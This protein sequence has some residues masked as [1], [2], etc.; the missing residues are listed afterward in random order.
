MWLK[1]R[2]LEDFWHLKSLEAGSLT[3][4][5]HYIYCWVPWLTDATYCN[6]VICIG[7][8]D[9]LCQKWAIVWW[10]NHKNKTLLCIWNNPLISLSV[11]TL[12]PDLF[13]MSVNKLT[14]A[15]SWTVEKMPNLCC[16]LVLGN[17]NC[18]ISQIR[19]MYETQGAPFRNGSI[20]ILK[21]T[22]SG[23]TTLEVAFTG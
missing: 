9:N 5:L 17:A 7:N 23:R 21:H 14:K 1:A 12:Q 10:K 22:S 3:V 6:D 2:F 19:K 11:K 4:P 8:T 16:C 15:E 18:S 13:A 20:F